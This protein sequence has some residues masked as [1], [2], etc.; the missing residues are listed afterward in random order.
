MSDSPRTAMHARDP[1]RVPG[2][3]SADELL[4]RIDRLTEWG[5]QLTPSNQAAERERFLDA[6]AAGRTYEPA[7]EYDP[8]DVRQLEQLLGALQQLDLDRLPAELRAEYEG[9]VE[10]YATQLELVGAFAEGDDRRVAEL[11]ARLYHASGDTGLVESA[12]VVLGSLGTPIDLRYAD[13]SEVDTGRVIASLQATLDDYGLDWRIEAGRSAARLRVST[14]ERLIVVNENARFTDRDIRKIT[15]HEIETHVL[16]CE[17]GRRLWDFSLYEIGTPDTESIEE[18]LALT[19]ERRVRVARPE[20]D[21]LIALHV[22]GIDIASRTTFSETFRTIEA[23]FPDSPGDAFDRVVRWRRGARNQAEP[24][25]FW[26]DVVYFGGLRR[27]DA[28]VRSGGNVKSLY[29]GRMNVERN[30][31]AIE[32]LLARFGRIDRP[33]LL[34]PHF[35]DPD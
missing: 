25:A 10:A 12:A 27:V 6:A 31:T 34:L 3:R 32:D 8:V 7:F 17:N 33:P 9:A 26:K 28:F 21:R 19:N 13:A 18:G 11:S 15:V 24:F 35:L 5:G 16:R 23:L 30:V 29:Y 4:V 1:D 20:Y 14:A 2:T 22:V